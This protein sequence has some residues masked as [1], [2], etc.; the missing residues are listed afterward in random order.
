MRQ[1]YCHS[2]TI[3]ITAVAVRCTVRRSP[4]VCMDSRAAQDEEVWLGNRMMAPNHRIQALELFY[5]VSSE[6]YT[7]VPMLRS[8]NNYCPG[9]DIGQSP[10]GAS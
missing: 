5:I 6:S 3:P 10:W 2:D 1:D 7:E 4:M 9:L 8:S